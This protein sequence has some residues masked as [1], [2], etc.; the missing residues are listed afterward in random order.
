MV[1]FKKFSLDFL[2]SFFI[3]A[4]L[5]LSIAV[6]G[7]Y[8]L[9]IYRNDNFVGNVTTFLARWF[10]FPVVVF[11]ADEIKSGLIGLNFVGLNEYEN[12]LKGL[13]HFYSQTYE[14]NLDQP[15]QALVL[16]EIRKIN[17]DQLVENNLI[18]TNLI[19]NG[20]YLK[21]TETSQ[22]WQTL[23][24][25][26]GSDQE[27]DKLIYSIYGL[28]LIDF[29]QNIFL[30]Q[31]AM[32]KWQEFLF[33]Q[34]NIDKLTK[35]EALDIKHR[36]DSGEDF[37]N[38]AG[39]FSDDASGYQGGRL[40]YASRGIWLEEFEQ[41]AFALKK[42]GETSQPVRTKFGYHLIKLNGRRFNYSTSQE[43]IKVSQILIAFP[44]PADVLAR[45]LAGEKPKLKIIKLN[46]EI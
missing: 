23:R 16:G 2:F 46:K 21:P 38:L 39:Q 35:A 9:S 43:E 27:L 12:N 26:A 34:K 24:A 45:W 10:D 20:I 30:P 7:F 19:R 41:A 25:G 28:S 6:F 4:I 36:L 11:K 5:F 14:A 33:N 44:A 13:K 15:S 31:L 17:L 40:D 37:A 8:G 42:I 29:K 3:L 18:K 32:E 22:R 1:N